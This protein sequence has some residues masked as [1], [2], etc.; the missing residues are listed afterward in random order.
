MLRGQERW[1]SRRRAR[2]RLAVGLVVLPLVAGCQNAPAPPGVAPSGGQSSVACPAAQPARPGTA[3]QVDY[4]DALIWQG[5]EYLAVASTVPTERGE[6]VT[7]IA[8]SIEQITRAAS[9]SSPLPGQ[10][11]RPRAWRWGRWC[12]PYLVNPRVAS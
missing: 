4:V 8:C 1:W 11:E 10:T 2:Q 5:Q 12:M 7:T 3:Q 9:C 6:E